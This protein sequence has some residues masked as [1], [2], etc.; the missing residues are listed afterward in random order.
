MWNCTQVER[1]LFAWRDW[2]NSLIE[3]WAYGMNLQGISLRALQNVVEPILRKLDLIP[4][5]ANGIYWISCACSDFSIRDRRTWERIIIPPWLPPIINP[6]VDFTY[7]K[8]GKRAYPLSIF[9]QEGEEGYPLTQNN[10]HVI[11]ETL[12][13]MRGRPKQK[14]AIRGPSPSYP[15]RLAVKCAVMKNEGVTYVEIAKKYKLKITKPELSLQSDTARYLVRKGRQ[16][17]TTL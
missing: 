16:L 11:L 17:L 13:K 4:S 9:G 5:R 15:D 2:R 14:E 6:G 7:L 12:S 1:A 3:H 8:A 10:K